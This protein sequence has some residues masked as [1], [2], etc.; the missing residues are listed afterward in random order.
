MTAPLLDL[1][2]IWSICIGTLDCR[3]TNTSYRR[4]CRQQKLFNALE[5]NP[6]LET[7]LQ[8]QYAEPG[9]ISMVNRP[10]WAHNK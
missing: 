8:T 6:A 1:H 5:R 10:G 4:L 3:I 9:S 2:R 7:E